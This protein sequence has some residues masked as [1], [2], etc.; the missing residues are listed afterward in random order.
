[1]ACGASRLQPVAPFE[2][3]PDHVGRDHHD[4]RSRRSESGPK[5]GPTFGPGVPPTSGRLPTSCPLGLLKKLSQSAKASRHRSRT[6]VPDLKNGVTKP[7]EDTEKNLVF[8]G[9]FVRS[10]TPFL[11]SG[12]SVTAQK[13][14]HTRAEKHL[15]LSKSSDSDARADSYSEIE[16]SAPTAD[17]STSATTPRVRDLGLDHGS[18]SQWQ[19]R[20]SA[21]GRTTS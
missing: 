5:P 13:W 12:T 11:R 9:S 17:N 21:H 19:D 8:F 7:T 6:E 15:R 16:R 18:A 2:H 4:R 10:V 3:V 1:M 20:S 14:S